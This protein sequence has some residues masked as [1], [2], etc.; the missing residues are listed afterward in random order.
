MS[1]PVAPDSAL[2]RVHLSQLGA[3]RG[4]IPLPPSSSYRMQAYTAL[5]ADELIPRIDLDSKALSSS[6]FIRELRRTR[7]KISLLSK[8]FH[9][10]NKARRWRYP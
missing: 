10:L 3:C 9:A 2:L 6:V 8:V 1:N 5:L 4:C 7:S